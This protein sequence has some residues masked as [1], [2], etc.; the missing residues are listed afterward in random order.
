MTSRGKV[1]GG[2]T[3][4][5]FLALR[6]PVEVIDVLVDWSERELSRCRRVP[7]DHVH[8]TVAFLGA[9]PVAAVPGIV[10]VL[11]DTVG[12]S[13]PPELA[14][15]RWRETRSVGMIVLRD[16]TGAATRLAEAV[17][18]GLEEL[19]VYRR[20]KRRW[21]PHVTLCRFREP[22]RLQPP[23]PGM[24]TFVPSDAAA[25]LSRL[26]PSGARYEV[27][28]TTTFMTA[29]GEEDGAPALGGKEETYEPR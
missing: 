23:L 7:R 19:G 24:G 2:E 8:V 29:H 18:G 10:A 4:R 25:F 28:E 12:A 1:G 27:L 11:R 6:L 3:L 13:E 17:H 26:H 15:D 5:L 20:E 14:I 21:L 16:I 9:Q 22:P